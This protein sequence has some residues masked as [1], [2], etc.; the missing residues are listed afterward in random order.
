MLTQSIKFGCTIATLG[1]VL[2]TPGCTAPQR[3]TTQE[4]ETLYQRKQRELEEWRDRAWIICNDDPNPG[5]CKLEV[6][7]SWLAAAEVLRKAELASHE[8]R[9]KDE[10]EARK[11]LEKRLLD[12]IP[13]F[14]EIKDLIP[15]LLGGVFFEDKE[16]GVDSHF[17]IN[18]EPVYAGTV[19][20]GTPTNIPCLSGIVSLAGTASTT[21]AGFANSADFQAEFT[22]SDCEIINGVATSKIGG[23]FIKI[24]TPGLV[25]ET[26]YASVD[27]SYPA[28]LSVNASGHGT[29]DC[30]VNIST[31]PGP[32]V[33]WINGLQH[34]QM[35]IST[36]AD[37]SLG[38][39]ILTQPYLR[40]FPRPYYRA[41]DFN[42]DGV[43]DSL[44][45]AAFLAALSA[46]D[47]LA[48]R[49]GDGVWD[50]TDYSLWQETFN[51]ESILPR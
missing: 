2:F 18:G 49:N 35:P 12:L 37:G 9:W 45:E 14:P 5:E 10:S 3:P 7:K 26:V 39:V 22:A 13:K 24:A 25:V 17:F 11:E 50:Q 19:I 34:L 48:D 28:S 47:D 51:D 23:G 16:I 46:H 8:L 32:W 38:V 1:M 36:H 20:S 15:K 43:L 41:A 30:W 40:A 33:N 31:P 29:L 42:Q 21:I 4:I 27:N 6:R 44:D